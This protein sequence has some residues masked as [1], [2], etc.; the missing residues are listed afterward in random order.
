MSLRR[1][2]TEKESLEQRTMQ[3]ES[4]RAEFQEQTDQG[5]LQIKHTQQLLNR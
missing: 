2:G 3:M 1:L 5:A 4:E